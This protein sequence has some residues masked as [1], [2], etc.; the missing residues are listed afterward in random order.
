MK[1]RIRGCMGG[2]FFLLSIA[3]YFYG[4]GRSLLGRHALR[5]AL[6]LLFA[7]DVPLSQLCILDEFCLAWQF[8]AQLLD[9]H[10]YRRRDRECQERPHDPQQR[11]ARD[12]R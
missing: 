10:Q 8:H 1:G 9:E 7:S 4:N 2:D 12:E 6:V 5:A 11:C 3:R